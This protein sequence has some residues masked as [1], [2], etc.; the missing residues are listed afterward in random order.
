MI[1]T[2]RFSIVFILFSLLIV[3]G[4]KTDQKAGARGY[5]FTV[6]TNDT[7]EAIAAEYRNQGV[8]VTADQI[9]AANPSLKTATDLQVGVQ[10]FIPD[11]NAKTNL[12]AP[13]LIKP[14]E[15]ADF[16]V[17][18]ITSEGASNLMSEKIKIGTDDPDSYNF[19]S[20]NE[21][22][23][24][25]ETVNQYRAALKAGYTAFSTA[26]MTTESWFI[27]ANQ[28]LDFMERAK[29]SKHSLF[30]AQNLKYLPVSLLNWNEWEE[31]E[32]LKRDAEQGMTLR[33]CTSIFAKHHIH[34]LKIKGN[35]MT[36]SD[37]GCHYCASELARGDLDGDGY[38]DAL[39][40]VTIYY[41]GG[42]G[43]GYETWVISKTD[44]KQRQLRLCLPD[45]GIKTTTDSAS[46]NLF[47]KM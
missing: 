2:P 31:G 45:T 44:P 11:P 6:Q 24:Q 26:D 19:L 32:R 36:F 29:P 34:A 42:S 35:T 1:L 5:F 39:I 9:L 47:L 13:R 25:I 16:T 12:I 28:V 27:Q 20:L 38:E 43:R 15:F 10:L 3:A 21:T 8:D 4:C 30:S 37:E 14:L 17:S 40:M 33:D 46:T 7:L 18:D 22:N 23:I 41:R